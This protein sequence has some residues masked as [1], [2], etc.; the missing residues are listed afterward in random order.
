MLFSY[1]KLKP[2]KENERK[3]A[4]IRHLIQIKEERE[5]LKHIKNK[6]LKT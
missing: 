6:Q 3:K 1:L 5:N 2:R 4:I